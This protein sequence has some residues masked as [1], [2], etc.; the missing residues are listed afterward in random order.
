MSKG[1]TEVLNYY[2]ALGP[3]TD[4]C[5]H[6]DLYAGLPTDIPSLCKVV[7]GNLIH[8]FWAERYG[9]SLSDEE[10]SPLYVRPVS[11]KLEFIRQCDDRPLSEVRSIDKRQVGNCRDFSLLLT[12]IL[13]YQGVPARA[14]CGFG[15][16]FLPDHF[17]DHWV[18]EYWNA[19]DGRWV[20]VDA[21]LDNFQQEALEISFDPLDVP[22]DQF[23]IAGQGWQMC[24][25]GQATPEQFGIFDMHGWWFIWDDIVRD[26]LSL[27]KIEILPWDH[28]LGIFTHALED[29]LTDDPEELAYY[30][31]IADL[32][33]A[34]DDAFN[35]VLRAVA[36]DPRWHV[37]ESWI[38]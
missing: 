12:S 4:P 7:Q 32:T 6:A 17:E 3:M 8:V 11:Q 15:A 18:C 22:R 30:D 33:L 35:D 20:F 24:R 10:Q 13:R 19:D 2:T 27:N 14:R 36:G 16:Y 37:P 31:S 38:Q 34:G 23:V 1:I 9:R 5:R 29:P 28:E 25:Q 21:Q 26:L